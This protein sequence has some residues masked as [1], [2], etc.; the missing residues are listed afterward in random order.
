MESKPAKY[1]FLRAIF[2]ENFCLIIIL[3]FYEEDH[4]KSRKEKDG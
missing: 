2:P 3:L 4:R 1:Q